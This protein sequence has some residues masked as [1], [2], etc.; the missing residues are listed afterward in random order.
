MGPPKL[1]ANSHSLRFEWMIVAPALI[2]A[3]ATVYVPIMGGFQRNAEV[4]E[5]TALTVALVAASILS[6]ALAHLFAASWLGSPKPTRMP[7]YLFGD[8]SQAWPA[9]HPAGHE[10]LVGASGPF[11]NLLLAAAGYLLWNAAT[12]PFPERCCAFFRTL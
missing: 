1:A 10:F 11:A 5:V 7:L 6:H 12:Q 9:A 3:V 4:W 8:A 2:W